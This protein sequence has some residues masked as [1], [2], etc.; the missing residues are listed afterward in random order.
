MARTNQSG[1]RTRVDPDALPEPPRLSQMPVDSWFEEDD[2]R[3]AYHERLSVLEI[4][5]P[6]HLADNVLPEE[7]YPGFWRLID[8]QGVRQFLFMRERRGW[9]IPDQQDDY[10]PLSPAVRAFL[11]AASSQEE[12]RNSYGGGSP[13]SLGHGTGEIY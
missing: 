11:R 6:K 5:V 3:T 12:P 2:E 13:H 1:K 10:R 8:I 9:K 7:E 4:L